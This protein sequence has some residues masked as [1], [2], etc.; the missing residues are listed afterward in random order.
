MSK[1][2][3]LIIGGIVVASLAGVGIG[4]GGKFISV[5][6]ELIMLE[7]GIDEQMGKIDSKLQR[8]NDLIP[9]VVESVKGTM[10]QEEKVF[11]AIADARSKMAGAKT[12][13]EKFEASNNLS[14]AI[15]R[16][17]VVKESYPELKS[18]EQV[19]KL[20]TELEGTENRISVERDKYNEA[21]KEYNV[22]IRKFP[23]SLVANITGHEKKEYFEA[24]KGAETAP[25]VNLVD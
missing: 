5:N 9:S 18:N 8:R 25:T 13:E 2:K 22:A 3:G 6:N 24:S 11:T 10:K 15:S 4:V 12:D 23:N 17:L 16:L 7:E 14:S 1:N 19:S 21:V 20:I